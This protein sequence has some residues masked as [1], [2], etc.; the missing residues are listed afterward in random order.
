MKAKLVWTLVIAASAAAMGIAIYGNMPVP[1]RLLAAAC[2]LPFCPGMAIV[3][4]LKIE[5]GVAELA[6]A[7]ALS[8]AIETIVAMALVYA[9][10]WSPNLVLAIIIGITVAGTVAQW[11]RRPVPP[12]QP[13][14]GKAAERLV[15]LCK[16]P[17][18]NYWEFRR[19]GN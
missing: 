18:R 7:I 1:V 8:I 19:R 13:S 2:F 4:L 10:L 14:D 6:V 15:R 3:R 5:D 9:R 12:K 16:P 11:V 17:V